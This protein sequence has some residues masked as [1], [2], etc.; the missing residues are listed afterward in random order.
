MTERLANPFQF[1]DVERR[2]P[3]KRSMQSRTEEFV[4]IYDPFTEQTAAEQSHRCLECGNPYCEW[5]CPVHNLIPNWLKLLAEGRLF[6]AAELSHQTNTL[7]EVCGRVCPQDRLCE[8]ACTL[9]DGFGAVTIGNAE[10]Y[11]TDTALAMGWRPDLSD[12]IPT[13]KRVAIIGAGPAGLGCA[14][15]LVRNGVSPVVFDRY[16]EIGGLLT[17]GI[18]QFKLEKQ[19]MQRR[20]EVFEGMGV[21]FRLNTEIGVDIDADDLLEEFDA[22]FLGMGTYTAMQGG[23]DGE[24]LPGVHKALDY[25]VGNVNEKMGYAQPKENFIDLKGKTVVVLG[26]GDTAMDC[27]RTAVRQ[28]AEQVFCVY[29]RDEEN[30]PGSRREVQNAREEG[31]QFLF[32]R[33]PVGVVDYFGEAIGV[34]VVETRLGEPGPD[35][36]RRP[37]QVEG[38]EATLEADAIIMAF[39]FQPSPNQWMA[40]MEIGLNEWKGVIAPEHQTFKFQTTNP[41][42]FAGGDMVR[43]SD[44]VVTAIWEGR[45]AAEGILDYLAV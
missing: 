41:K 38:S 33:Q 18:P 13:G 9:H 22:V 1:L 45:Q 32:N 26:G 8:G 44:L 3:N 35:G 34:K 31:V 29:R 7:P 16:P 36:R 6:E 11:I 4:E 23:F 12:V 10:K 43:G 21:E 25:L 27:V 2:D 39:G 19:V 42:V 28:Q 30:M 20:R 15:I 14:D 24:D 37:E 40:D 5:K 17:F